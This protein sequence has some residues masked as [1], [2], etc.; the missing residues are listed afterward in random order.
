MCDCGNNKNQD[1]LVPHVGIITDITQETPDVKTF[2]VNAPGGGKLFEHMP[3][4]CAM[5][6]VPGVGEGM[7]SIT[8][9]PT[10]KEYMEFSIKRCGLLTEYLHGLSV[11]DEIT[12]RGP[13]GNNFPVDT[14]LKGK[15]LL[16]IAGGIG[17]APLRS[18]INYCIDNRQDYGTIDIL[19][20]SRSADDLVKL[21]EIKEKWMN[22][23]GVNVYLTIDR[24]QEGWD[25]HVGFV[26]AYL[27][28]IDFSTDKIGLIC[29][30]PI[31]I[32]FVLQGMKELGFTDDQV[33]TTL[34]LRMK[35]GVGKCGRCNIGSKYVCKDGPVFRFDQ[36]EE[37]PD[38]Y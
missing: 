19:Y 24:E 31:M 27:K 11:G 38:E 3:G 26:P 18:V 12:V 13:Y 9:S 23:E 14:E 36:I 30:P 6:C 8:S 16:F 1:I 4:Q 28:E 34:E 15:N 7:F 22:T 33:Y 17:L 32:K 25:G 29:G 37:M 10:N 2:R 35:C 20:G 21:K 5:V